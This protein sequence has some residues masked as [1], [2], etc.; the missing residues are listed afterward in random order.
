MF[1]M[2]I[3][4]KEKFATIRFQIDWKS[5]YA[6]HCDCFVAQQVNFW[7]DIFPPRLYEKLMNKMTNESISLEFAPGKIVPPSNGRQIRK[8][9]RRQF[10][11]HFKPGDDVTTRFGRC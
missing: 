9:K 2:D 10:N 3:K 11:D 5:E 1:N 7:R 6:R 8:I 4:S